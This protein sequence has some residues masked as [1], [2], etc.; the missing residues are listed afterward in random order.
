MINRYFQ[1]AR[2]YYR[3]PRFWIFGGLY[4]LTLLWWHENLDQPLP[5]AIGSTA[6]AMALGCFVA[7]HLRRQFSTAAAR[8]WPDFV[9]RHLAVGLA[10]SLVVW[11]VLPLTAAWRGGLSPEGMVALHSIAGMFLALVICWR[12]A[13]FFLVSLPLLAMVSATRLVLRDRIVEWLDQLVRGEA[14][15]SAAAMIAVAALLQV[16][17][18]WVLMRLGDRI[19]P[20]SDDLMAEV[21]GTEGMAGYF[22]EFLLNFRDRAIRH[23]LADAGHFGWNVNRWRLPVA[24]SVWHFVLTVAV[25]A[26]VD[27][28]GAYMA[29]DRSFGGLATL[30]AVP[31]MIVAPFSQWHQRRIALES[32]FMRPIE[33]RQ[34]YRQMAAAFALDV[35]AWTIAA[36]AL[37]AMTAVA[38]SKLRPAMELVAV[39]SVVIGALAVWLYGVGV[40]LYRFRYWIP[41]LMALSVAWCF[42]VVP[43]IGTLSTPKAHLPAMVGPGVFSA[44]TVAFGLL[45]ARLAYGYW[46]DSDVV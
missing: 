29:N 17:A 34:F 38:V 43:I 42:F 24:L 46:T 27:G 45:A 3:R 14:P 20:L 16:V 35:A 31:L 15:R 26:A 21:P 36:V 37:V 11:V 23:R 44:V 19:A 25:V 2:T 30:V 22:G 13:I 40:A 33:R 9:A 18:A 1:I 4:L 12:Q 5:R 7:L 28:L 41:L 8:L 10:A 32:E 6:L 39:S